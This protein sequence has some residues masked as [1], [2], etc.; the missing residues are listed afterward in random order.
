MISA[1]GCSDVLFQVLRLVILYGFMWL[2]Q[3]FAIDLEF[4]AKDDYWKWFP[5]SI[6]IGATIY[7]LM[8]LF[9]DALMF[10]IFGLESLSPFDAVMLL[11]D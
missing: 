2:A 5:V 4:I 8:M 6:F 11:D 1:Y 7:W 10:G 3:Y 9:F